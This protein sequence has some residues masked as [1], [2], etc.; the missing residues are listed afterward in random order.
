LKFDAKT[1]GAGDIFRSIL[2]TGR[3]QAPTQLDFCGNFPRFSNVGLEVQ[4]GANGR[5]TQ[6]GLMPSWDFR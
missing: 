2:A 6:L 4:F 5:L 3:S 1:A